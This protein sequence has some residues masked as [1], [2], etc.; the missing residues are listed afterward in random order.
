DVN[1]FSRYTWRVTS[2]SPAYGH[3]FTTDDVKGAQAVYRFTGPTVTW[4]TVTGPDQGLAAVA[5]DGH[6]KGS[7]NDYAAARHH[8]V[9][10]TFAGLGAGSHTIVITV[11]GRKGSAK[12]TGTAVSVDAFRSTSL[13]STPNVS[14]GWARRFASVAFGG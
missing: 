1:P 10:R 12:G 8:R 2:A 9:A 11:T 3:S 13:V 4:Y 14:Y 7:V 5:I 6:S